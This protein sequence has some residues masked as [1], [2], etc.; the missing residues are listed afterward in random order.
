MRSAKL[1][2]I[3]NSFCFIAV[4]KTVIINLQ[5][6]LALSQKYALHDKKDQLHKI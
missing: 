5:K 1:N 6:F 4:D 2:V 3:V